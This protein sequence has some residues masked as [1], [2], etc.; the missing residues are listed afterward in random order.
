ALFTLRELREEVMRWF[1]SRA[2]WILGLLLLGLIAAQGQ[3]NPLA[4]DEGVQKL[5]DWLADKK[6]TVREEASG[7]LLQ[8]GEKTLPDLEKALKSA[9]PEVQRRAEVLIEKIRTG[10]EEKA[11]QDLAARVNKI[12]IHEVILA[13]AKRQGQDG[14]RWQEIETVLG[15]ILAAAKQIGHQK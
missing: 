7:K 4:P 3:D 13:L 14:Q 9:D 10:L 5:V 12:N 8:L 2:V 11:F 15:F 1:R 6:F